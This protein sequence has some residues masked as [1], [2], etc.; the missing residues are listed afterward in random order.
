MNNWINDINSGEVDGKF[1]VGKVML[2]AG[3]T[4]LCG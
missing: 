1:S 2:S 4:I 3:N